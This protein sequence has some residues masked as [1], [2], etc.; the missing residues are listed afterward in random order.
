MRVGEPELVLSHSGW[1]LFLA[2]DRRRAHRAV[3]ASEE[4]NGAVCFFFFLSFLS[5][6]LSKHV[7]RGRTNEP[8]WLNLPCRGV[9]L[10]AGGCF[11]A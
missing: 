7:L 1:K 8:A 2:A 11:V 9:C 3:T 10:R 6:I 5:S 4:G